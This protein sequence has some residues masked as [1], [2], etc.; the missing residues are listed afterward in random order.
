ME[1]MFGLMCIQIYTI[2]NYRSKSKP[3]SE[4]KEMQG[5][6]HHVTSHLLFYFL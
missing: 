6:S 3:E 4:C 5:I 1:E 2:Q